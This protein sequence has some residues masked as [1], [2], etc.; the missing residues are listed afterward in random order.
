MMMK[1]NIQE[2]KKQL[3]EK[4]FIEDKD[5]IEDIE[6]QD[7]KEDIKKFFIPKKEDIIKI[8]DEI[9]KDPFISSF[10]ENLEE[11]IDLFFRDYY[12]N[13]IASIIQSDDILYLNILIY[14]TQLRF[15]EKPKN[16][17]ELY[18]SKCILWTHNYREEFIFLFKMFSSFQKL[19][20][21]IN[22]LEKVKQ[23]IETNKISY[24]ISEHHPKFK[25]LIDKPFLLI[26]DS[27]FYNLLEFIETLKSKEVLEIINTLSEIIQSA[28]IF[29][30]NLGLK[31]KDFYRF[32]TLFITI[33]LF[34]D[35]NV[36]DKNIINSYIKYIKNERELLI[37][38]KIEQI[39][40]ELR[41]QIHLLKKCLP[42]CEKKIIL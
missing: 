29:N 32:K 30:T 25:K 40:N 37:E 16:G 19:F 26:I 38:N 24:I 4:F 9:F 28:E 36:Y 18:Y 6:F 2:D 7:V 13:F 34:N 8:K 5:N 42:D 20:K 39:P 1:K 23:K 11:L 12:F 15:G 27:F 17:S 35:K 33:K 3:I 22:V 10:K 41:N 31:S 14:L 21:N